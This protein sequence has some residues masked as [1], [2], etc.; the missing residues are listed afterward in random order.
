[1]RRAHRTLHVTLWILI[2]PAVVAALF[3]ALTHRPADPVSEAP[4]AVVTEAP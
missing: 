3:V 1:M 2:A 4:D